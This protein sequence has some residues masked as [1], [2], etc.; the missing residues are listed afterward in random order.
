M[1]ETIQPYDNIR[2]TIAWNYA[3]KSWQY[4]VKVEGLALKIF[5]DVRKAQHYVDMRGRGHRDVPDLAKATKQLK[6]P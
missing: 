4:H 6:K 1:T 2:V 3:A 5:S